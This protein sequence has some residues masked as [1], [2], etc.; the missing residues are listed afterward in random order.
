LTRPDI[1][2]ALACLA[3]GYVLGGIPF[4]YIVARFRG[5]DVREVGTFGYIV[6][7]FRGV[8]VREV[9]SGNVGATNVGRALGRSWG[10]LVLVLDIGKGLLPVL[11]LAPAMAVWF[12][13]AA[14]LTSSS[15]MGLGAILGHVFTPFLG[16]RGG[17]GVATSIGVFAALVQYWIALPLGAYVVARRL[18]G[19]VSLG[20]ISLAVCLPVAA[21]LSHRGAGAR[22]WPVIG[23][24]SLV[25]AL[26]LLRHRSNIVRLLTGTEHTAP[27]G[28]AGGEGPSPE[29]ERP[30]QAGRPT[31]NSGK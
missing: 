3:T 28:A 24:A 13:G 2:A 10:W 30:P 26:I 25:G 19:Y 5:V 18:T 12:G 21:W 29:E 23:L 20:S 17:K 22:A 7:R 27:G 8:D 14:L 11:L 31:E 6:A 1:V 9:G 4:G 15:A 16:L